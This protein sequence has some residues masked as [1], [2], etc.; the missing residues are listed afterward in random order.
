MA[1]G[2][3]TS[4]HGVGHVGAVTFPQQARDK[5]FHTT[6]HPVIKSSSP[7]EWGWCYVTTVFRVARRDSADARATRVAGCDEEVIHGGHGSEPL[8]I[9]V[10]LGSTRRGRQSHK[11]ARFIA[12]RMSRNERIE[13]E[14]L[15]LAEYDFPIMEERL[16]FRDDPPPGLREFSE[17]VARSDSLV[18]VTPEYNNGYPGVL[19]NALDYLLPEYQ[20][21]P[22][23]IV[24]VSAGG[25]GGINCLA[26]LRC[27]AGDGRFT[28]RRR[29][30]CRALGRFDE[31]GNTKDER[32][33]DGARVHR[34]RLGSRKPSR[35]ESQTAMTKT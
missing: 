26:Q 2:T 1:V 4:V 17:K 10:I 32:T 11:V 3:P 23:A 29:C 31:D 22:I 35:S 19:K 20:R 27:D 25:F 24:T 16:R 7:R 18:I 21:K 30:R 15:D 33:K 28:T 12:E 14:I 6:N 13:T 5:T 34:G 9:P 8:L